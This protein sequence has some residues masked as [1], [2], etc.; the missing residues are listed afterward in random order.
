MKDLV[1]V[2]W[3]LIT[4][5]L[6]LI[7]AMSPVYS[8]G[9]CQ[10]GTVFAWFKASETDW[11]NATAH[12]V[13][14]RGEI[15]TIKIVVTPTV[16]VS[17]F[18]LKLHEF[19]T[20]VYQ[21]LTGPTTIEDLLECRGNIS[22]G[23]SH[24]YLWNIQVK[25]DTTWVN[26]YAPLEVFVQFNK[27]DVETAIVDFDV[28][29][30]FIRDEPWQNESDHDINGTNPLPDPNHKQLCSFGIAGVCGIVSFVVILRRK[31]YKNR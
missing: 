24:S 22:V 30:G 1:R 16:D 23:Q 9:Q 10:Y 4:A 26:G 14:Y 19:G 18:Y 31:K 8:A 13:L 20:P 3:V 15:F 28:F 21:V 2:V 12:P 5:G 29:T 25:N 17:A 11:E 7:I 27:N 6:L